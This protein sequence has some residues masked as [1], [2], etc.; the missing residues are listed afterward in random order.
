MKVGMKRKRKDVPSFPAR[1][2]QRYGA[3][4]LALSFVRPW[5]GNQLTQRRRVPAWKSGPDIVV[6][7]LS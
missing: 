7:Q 5:A 2:A 3:G 1:F 6:G 4:S